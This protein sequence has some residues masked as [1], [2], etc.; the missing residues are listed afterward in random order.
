M[1]S[2]LDT[3]VG[4]PLDEL[5]GELCL[6]EDVRGA[7]L[8]NLAPESPV[9]QVYRL[10]LAC[11]RSEWDA[12]SQTAG[13]MGIPA[14]VVSDLYIEAAIWCAEIFHARKPGDRHRRPV[15]GVDPLECRASTP[16]QKGSERESVRHPGFI[17]FP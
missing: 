1:F 3:M 15:P 5:L 6:A 13:A 16:I 9:A 4:R 2:L 10:V 11:E 14:E 17:W 8:G 7:L 12:I